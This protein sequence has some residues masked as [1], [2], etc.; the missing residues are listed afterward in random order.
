MSQE[1]DFYTIEEIAGMVKKNRGTVYNR[2][3]LLDIQT[4]K[5]P[6]DRRTYVAAVDVQKI[7]TVIEK[8]WMAMELGA[9]SED[10]PV[11]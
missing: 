8:P 7:V 4:H 6:M 3:K 9:R 11:A 1:K 10:A 5:F 2:I